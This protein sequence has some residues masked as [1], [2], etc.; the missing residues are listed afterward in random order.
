M[1][2]TI[3]YRDVDTGDTHTVEFVPV[4]NFERPAISFAW[5]M[6]ASGVTVADV[7]ILKAN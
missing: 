6:D 7:E 1:T 5:E 4:D 2:Y 3:R